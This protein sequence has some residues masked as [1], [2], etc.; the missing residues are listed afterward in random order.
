MTIQNFETLFL[1]VNS[2]T[3]TVFLPKERF[4]EKR[5]VSYLFGLPFD[6]N[7]T[8]TYNGIELIGSDL[9]NCYLDV[10][11]IDKGC[12]ISKQNLSQFAKMIKHKIDKVLDF[13]LSK[14]SVKTTISDNSYLPICVVYSTKFEQPEILATNNITLQAQS[15]GPA[16]VKLSSIGGYQLKGK[17]IKQILV[18]SRY[19]AYITIRTIDNR[20]NIYDMPLTLLTQATQINDSNI[21]FDNL[22]IDTDNSFIRFEESNNINITFKY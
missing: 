19:N 17:Q 1:E 21:R 4:L 12:V 11:D 6:K 13:D 18:G 8:D 7:S 22:N 14:I 10:Y 3:D 5:K 20:N 9:I 16:I 15:A 2:N